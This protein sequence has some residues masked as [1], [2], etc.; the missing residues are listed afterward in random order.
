MLD[1]SVLKCRPSPL[2]YLSYW[3][4]RKTTIPPTSTSSRPSFLMVSM[5][6]PPSMSSS[7]SDDSGDE[8]DF[9]LGASDLDSPADSPEPEA[10]PSYLH[11]QKL[12]AARAQYSRSPSDTGSPEFQ[13]AGMTERI[14]YLTSHLQS[15]PK[16]FSTRRGLV[17][18]VNKRRRLLNYLYAEDVERYKE[19]VKALGIRHK[20]P[21]R[22][23]GREEKYA[24][25]ASKKKN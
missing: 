24:K 16:D 18:L 14:L 6:Q 15:N 21:G 5:S 2:S 1:T 10:T 11:A 17:A 20:A 23:M 12:T 19:L 22:V 13:V 3:T 9:I 4:M 8:V 25:F 7:P